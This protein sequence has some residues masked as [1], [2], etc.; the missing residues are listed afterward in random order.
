MSR[1][2]S[3]YYRLDR[4]DRTNMPI[5]CSK[6]HLVSIKMLG[7][8]HVGLATMVTLWGVPIPN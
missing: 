2:I 4:Y 3:A 5:G 8:F 1:L 7:H 6:L